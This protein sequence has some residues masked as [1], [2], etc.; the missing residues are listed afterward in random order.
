L[1]RFLR[2]RPLRYYALEHDFHLLPYRVAH[3]RRARHTIVLGIVGILVFSAWYWVIPRTDVE[4]SVQYHEGLFNSINVDARV[5]NSGTV[6]L[7]GLHIELVVTV[8]G[9]GEARGGTNATRTLAPHSTLRLDAVAFK[10]DQLTTTYR[11]SVT[12]SYSG[13]SGP[14]VRTFDYVTEEPYM[15][16]YFESPLA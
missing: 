2:R 8:D 7:T 9:T 13:Q 1:D 10:G 14:V 11:I 12:A 4:L 5:V 6:A 16:L 3:S 15:N